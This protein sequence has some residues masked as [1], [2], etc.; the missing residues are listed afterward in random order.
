[1]GLQPNVSNA[2]GSLPTFSYGSTS[3]HMLSSP[4]HTTFSISPSDDQLAASYSG[5]TRAMA[6]RVMSL[7]CWFSQ[8]MTNPP[9]F[10][11]VYLLHNWFLLDWLVPRAKTAVD[12]GL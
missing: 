12:E 11:P 9:A 4:L 1:M 5:S 8:S 7:T 2:F 10:L 3:A 6:W